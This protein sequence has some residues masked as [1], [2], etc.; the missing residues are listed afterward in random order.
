MDKEYIAGTVNKG[1]RVYVPHCDL[2]SLK[3]NPLNPP[4]RTKPEMLVGLRREIEKAGRI[5]DPLHV[6]GETHVVQEG[7][8]RRACGM[9]IGLKEAPVF[10]YFNMSPAE[11]KDYLIRGLNVTKRSFSGPDKLRSVYVGAAKFPKEVRVLG[12]L[13]AMFSDTDVEFLIMEK[14]IGPDRLTLAKAFARYAGQGGDEGFVKQTLKWSA[15]HG[16]YRILQTAKNPHTGFT[17]KKLKG[18]VERIET[19]LPYVR[20]RVPRAAARRKQTK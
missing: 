6:H 17:G 20:P 4:N 15:T 5:L 11:I 18:L 3:P 19:N 9:L 1:Y 10:E 8:R 14:N 2:F 16:A 7:N 13:K 12:A